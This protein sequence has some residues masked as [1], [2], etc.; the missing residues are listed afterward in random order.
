M[1]ATTR[2]GPGSSDGRSMTTT[3]ATEPQKCNCFFVDKSWHDALLEI[4]T[5]AGIVGDLRADLAESYG[6]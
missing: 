4:E 5:H 1:T 2:P 6:G 3:E